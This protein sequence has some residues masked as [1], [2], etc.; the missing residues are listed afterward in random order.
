[1]KNL[2]AITIIMCGLTLFNGNI[3]AQK[4]GDQKKAVKTNKVHRP[5]QKKVTVVK[6]QLFPRNKVVV[7]KKQLFPRNKV[8]VVKQRKVRTVLQL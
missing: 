2:F 6:K 7:V 8:V 5:N 4:H 3:L 1:M